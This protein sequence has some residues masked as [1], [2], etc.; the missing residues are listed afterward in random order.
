MPKCDSSGY[1]FM[2]TVSAAIALLSSSLFGA[3]PSKVLLIVP[4]ETG[5]KAL[6]GID[7]IYETVSQRALTSAAIEK[8]AA[9]GGS[10]VWIG[11]PQTL[12]P[13]LWIG[14]F[15]PAETKLRIEAAE[16]APINLKPGSFQP[17]RLW[18]GFIKPTKELAYHNV[19]EEPRADLIPLLEARDRLGTVVGYPGFLFRHYAPSLAANRFHGSRQF[20]FL[21]DD[22]WAALPPAKWRELLQAIAERI[23]SGVQLTRVKADWGS[24]NVGEKVRIEAEVSNRRDHAVAVSLRFLVKESGD[25]DFR[26]IAEHRRTPTAEGVI[27]AHAQFIP[28]KVGACQ[29]RVE[30]LQDTKLAATLSASGTPEVI[31]QH[32][33][34]IVVHDGVIRTGPVVATSGLNI[35]IDGAPSFWIGTHYYPSTSWWDGTWRDFRPLI[36]DRD[37]AAMR[38]AGYRIV[39]IWI[40]PAL[41]EESLRAMDATVLLAEKHGIV[42]DVCLFTQWGPRIAFE[43]DDGELKSIELRT[44]S[45]FNVYGISF[46]HLDAQNEYVSKLA[47]RWKNARNIIFNLANETYIRDP[48]ESQMDVKV[49]QWPEASLPRSP[50]RDTKLFRRWAQEMTA[51]IRKAGA[52]QPVIPGFLFSSMG[53]G[54]GYLGNR[55]GDISPWHSYMSPED[56]A[57]TLSYVDTACSDRPVLLEEFGKGTWN[58]AEH[59]DQVIHYALAAGASAAMSYEWGVS[60]MSPELPP[61]ATFLNFAWPQKPDPRWF[62]ALEGVPKG[63]PKASSGFFPAASGFPYGSIYHGTPFPA[64][65]ASAVGRFATFGPMLARKP[66]RAATVVRVP[67]ADRYDLMSKLFPSF[68]QLWSRH[69]PYQVAQSDC[70]APADA[71]ELSPDTLKNV[72]RKTIPVS[73]ASLKLLAR[74]VQD[75]TLYSLFG[76]ASTTTAS[77]QVNSD[78]VTMGLQQHAMLVHGASGILF[79]EAAGTFAVNKNPVFTTQKGRLMVASRD[80]AGISQ[81]SKLHVRAT[82][83][84]RITFPRSIR[85]VHALVGHNQQP[86]SITNPTGNT[87]DIDTELVRYD[88]QVQF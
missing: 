17:S 19:V 31:D 55:D 64:E 82:E 14:T 26:T 16:G 57:A 62:A 49:R 35:T 40:D 30:L 33:T 54:D 86:I 15:Q 50:D 13:V 32:D 11:P 53:G 3:I 85:S 52:A 73:P 51:T 77:I 22:P 18:S 28:R 81:S 84:T 66:S 41:D 44:E 58:S 27:T 5:L 36:V 12:P 39:R 71:L 45:D 8:H 9:E 10:F 24:Y 68:K 61:H 6:G 23:E 70:P 7:P 79:T 83:P 25:S 74:E 63:W 37:F 46:R 80:G 29:I 56:T 60:W 65:A 21:L 20:Y 87:L 76:D 47:Q 75:G 42:L 67:K 38:Q 59:Y 4:D 88:L 34:G 43:K 48:D 1:N 2:R 78:E 69:V 72:G